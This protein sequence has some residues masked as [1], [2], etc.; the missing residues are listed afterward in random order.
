[1]IRLANTLHGETGLKKTEVPIGEIE[2]FDP[3]KSAIAFKD[4][5][6]TVDVSESPQ[7]RLGE[8]TYRPYQN[9]RVKLPTAAAMLLLCKGAAEVTEERNN[10]Q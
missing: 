3:F 10:V 6:I 8:V 9:E 2:R 5:T 1:L 4:G 7:F